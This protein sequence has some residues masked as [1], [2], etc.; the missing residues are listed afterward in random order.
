MGNVLY[1][2]LEAT[3]S[4]MTFVTVDVTVE[5]NNMP[6]DVLTLRGNVLQMKV[7]EVLLNAPTSAR[8]KRWS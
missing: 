5:L 7:Q 6:T 8:H 3:A 4:D 1:I 2:K